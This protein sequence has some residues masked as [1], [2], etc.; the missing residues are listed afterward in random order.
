MIGA[1]V[2]KEF[3]TNSF[4]FN[5]NNGLSQAF[6]LIISVLILV[7]EVILFN[8]II[9]RF[10]TYGNGALPFFIIF[11]SILVLIEILLSTF[12]CAKS[13]FNKVD[14]VILLTKPIK[15]SS[16]VI[17][18]LINLYIKELIS[19]FFLIYPIVISYGINFN[20]EFTYYIL[21]LIFIIFIPLFNLG[22]SL[23]LAIPYFYISLVLK[24]HHL[25]EIIFGVV[26]FILICYLYGVILSFFVNL[27]SSNTLLNFFNIENVNKMSN[28]SKYLVPINF[29]INFIN[30]SRLLNFI[31]ALLISILFL[32][33]GIFISSLFFLKIR[34][35][36]LSLS[37]K[38]SSHKKVSG[39]FSSLVKKEIN[40]YFRDTNYLLT[41]IA[42]LITSPYLIY[43]I[44]YAINDLFNNGNMALIASVI[45]GI[46]PIFDILIV[47][48][49]SSVINSSASTLI[50]NEKYMIRICKII[51]VSYYKQV[52]AKLLVPFILGTLSL[53][54]T[55]ITL[56][57]T[58]LISF[59]N[60]LISFT[61]ALFLV[62]SNLIFGVYKDLKKPNFIDNSN[63]NNLAS[64]VLYCLIVPLIILLIDLIIILIFYGFKIDATNLFT[65]CIV[66]DVVIV[67]ILFI[68]SLI[69]I[70][71]K[72]DRYFNLI[73]VN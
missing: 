53:L 10:K 46:I 24:K 8:N 25:I 31:F 39:V 71:R 5:K 51:P 54:I 18:K 28:I 23:I 47:I 67:F 19:I 2:K 27:V 11:S 45:P 35:S 64:G 15:S 59:T 60:G 36:D 56:V 72:V 49:F 20:L 52:I 66:I 22:V 70:K 1:L 61:L 73:E 7:I 37:K 63:S 12:R 16:I 30:E 6:S 33:V 41:Y 44:I 32:I 14:N 69:N 3:K 48:L 29:Y 65:I 13:L 34:R 43:L 9:A 57:S 17:S 55:V 62:L 26:V 42:L 4:K 50:S 58:S 38:Y 21:G 40:L 68:S